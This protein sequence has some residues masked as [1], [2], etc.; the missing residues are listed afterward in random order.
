MFDYTINTSFSKKV[1]GVR[2]YFEYFRVLNAIAE[3]Y[4][5]EKG[6]REL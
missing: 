1:I 3:L 5:A 6:A 2:N 4:Y